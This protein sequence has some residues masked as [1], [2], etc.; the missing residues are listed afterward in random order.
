MKD[1]GNIHWDSVPHDWTI[2]DKGAC[3]IAA[4]GKENK[5]IYWASRDAA[6]AQECLK[7]RIQ[8]QEK[9]CKK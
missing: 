6:M 8:K 5:L 1:A 9:V 4:N 7:K 3:Y 2:V